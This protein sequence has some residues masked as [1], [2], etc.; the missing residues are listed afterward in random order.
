MGGDFSEDSRQ[1]AAE[2]LRLSP[3]TVQAQPLNLGFVDSAEAADIPERG[4][5]G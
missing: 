5:G 1:E 4:E 3:M 2:H